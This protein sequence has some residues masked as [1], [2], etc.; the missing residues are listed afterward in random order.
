MTQK[1]K[2]RLDERLIGALLS[3]PTIAAAAKECGLSVRTAQRRMRE[4]EFEEKFRAARIQLVARTSTR[5]TAN[6]GRAA[7]VLRKI[8]D[9]ARA[10]A[11]ARVAA[12]T[13]TIRVTMEA[14]E[15]EELEKRIRQLEEKQD[16][17]L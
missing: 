6:S 1:G 10:T 2:S 14:F 11:G 5:L 17:P 8:F 3:K 15:I 9:D 16:A 7:A 13:N 4:P 12:A